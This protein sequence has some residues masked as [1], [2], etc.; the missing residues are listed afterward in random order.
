MS[1]KRPRMSANTDGDILDI[2]HNSF[3]STF[4][5]INSKKSLSPELQALISKAV[6]SSLDGKYFRCSEK[7]NNSFL[8]Q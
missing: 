6:S 4:K 3:Y 7:F 1:A 8:L 5:E 2:S